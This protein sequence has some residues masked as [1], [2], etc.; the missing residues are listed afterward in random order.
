VRTA[1]QRSGELEAEIT[2]LRRELADLRS[3]GNS[4]PVAAAALPDGCSE[5]VRT[6]IARLA[7]A[8]EN[9]QRRLN[10]DGIVSQERVTGAAAV[11]ATATDS[12]VVSPLAV[13]LGAVG[14][15]FGWGLGSSYVRRRDRSRRSRLRF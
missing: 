4:I 14:L 7:V 10:G 2:A 9:L 5:H 13:F 6:E 12:H 8:V 15:V 11:S 3:H 1:N